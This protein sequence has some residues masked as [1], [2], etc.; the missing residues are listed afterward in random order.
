MGCTVLPSTVA[1]RFVIV[2]SLMSTSCVL[3]FYSKK[4]YILL[5]LS[6]VPLLVKSDREY[7]GI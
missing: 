1:R 4:Q 5:L 7:L 2:A 3:D 6:G